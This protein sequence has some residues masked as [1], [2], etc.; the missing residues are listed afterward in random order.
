MDLFEAHEHSVLHSEVL[1]IDEPQGG[2]G[3]PGLCEH[4]LG[5]L[6]IWLV[7]LFL[8]HDQVDRPVRSRG[9]NLFRNIYFGP[10]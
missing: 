8:V 7:A 3:V 9:E 2:G 6:Q 1:S 4:T 5:S 10:F